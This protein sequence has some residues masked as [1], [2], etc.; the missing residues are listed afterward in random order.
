[1]TEMRQLA[2][3][4]HKYAVGQGFWDIR[5]L[6]TLIIPAKLMLVVSEVVEAMEADRKNDMENMGE[7]LADIII[8]VADLAG[9]LGI[10]LDVEIEKKM[11]FNRTRPKMHGKAY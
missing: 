10:D 6:E 4:C 2:E 8:R 1:M 5:H 11:A 9:R 3:D 7:E